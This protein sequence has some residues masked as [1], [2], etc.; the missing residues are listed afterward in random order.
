MSQLEIISVHCKENISNIY[1]V[2]QVCHII[3]RLMFYF[4]S[5]NRDFLMVVISVDVN[6]P[7]VNVFIFKTVFYINQTSLFI[8]VSSTLYNQIFCF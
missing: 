4:I 6:N 3:S 1:L 8:F 2:C 7:C 5:I